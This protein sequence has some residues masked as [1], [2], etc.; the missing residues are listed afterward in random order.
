MFFFCFLN[1]L[2]LLSMTS[3]QGFAVGTIFP[4]FCLIWQKCFSKTCLMFKSSLNRGQ[5]KPETIQSKL[6]PRLPHVSECIQFL[7]SLIIFPIY[8]ILPFQI[9]FLLIVCLLFYMK[10]SVFPTE[11][12][13]CRCSTQLTFM[14]KCSFIWVILL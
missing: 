8:D 5:V 7:V 14:L 6:L 9:P 2:P 3:S 11:E 4:P 10:T 1:F 13:E 12:K